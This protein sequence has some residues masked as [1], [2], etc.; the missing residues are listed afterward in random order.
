MADSAT[1]AVEFERGTME[2]VE[3]RLADAEER[4]IITVKKLA[5]HLGAEV[6]G[7]NIAAPLEKRSLRA[8][9]DALLRHRVI[10]FRGADLDHAQQVAFARQLG[11]PTIGHSVFGFEEGHPEVYSIAKYRLALPAVHAAAEETGSQVSRV[12]KKPW[13]G[14]HTDVTAAVNPPWCSVLRAT[15]VP[16]ESGVGDTCWTSLHAAYQDLSSEMQNFVRSLRGIHRYAGASHGSAGNSAYA[17]AQAAR[18]MVSNHPLVTRHPET[19]EPMLFASPLF[20]KSIVGLDKRESRALLERLWQHLVRPEFSVRFSW[21]N[22]DVACWD[23]RSTAHV[24]PSDIYE[25][26]FNRQLYRVTLLGEPL[27]A[28]SNG[29]PSLLLEG[30][31]LMT[32][33]D[34]LAAMARWQFSTKSAK[35]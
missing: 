10:F 7:P 34:E 26:D 24:A 2:Q 1:A 31:P 35:L 14:Y 30:Q 3:A 6:S 27:E 17:K 11:S 12:E 15:D 23:N 5:L 4:G 13:S 20:L 18:T 8:V 21:R 28:H 32:V 33:E 22:G 16:E 9:R 19:S 25:T 29:E